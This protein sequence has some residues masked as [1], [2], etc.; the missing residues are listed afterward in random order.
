MPTP[1]GRPYWVRFHLFVLL[2]VR[3]PAMEPPMAFLASELSIGGLTALLCAIVAMLI[4]LTIWAFSTCERLW[5]GGSFRRAHR[6]VG[7]RVH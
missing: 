1:W 6:P 3:W 7:T 5:S 2:F 4:P